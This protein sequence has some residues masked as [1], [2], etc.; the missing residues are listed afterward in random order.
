MTSHNTIR[1]DVDDD[2]KPVKFL[3]KLLDYV[4]DCTYFIQYELGTKT[5][6]QHWQGW[7]SH[8]KTDETFR[9]FFNGWTSRELLL[10]KS[11]EKSFKKVRRDLTGQMSYILKCQKKIQWGSE[12]L[13]Y[14][15]NIP[16][17]E[18]SEIYERIPVH[19]EK[20]QFLED[21]G[22]KIRKKTWHQETMEMLEEKCISRNLCLEPQINYEMVE[23]LVGS[24][25]PK[26][27]DQ[28]VYD[29]NVLGCM[30]H[31]EQRHPNQYN[32]RVTHMFSR[33][34]RDKYADVFFKN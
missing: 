33:N 32:N 2:T 24:R 10:K 34:F 14:Y 15:T 19:V 1:F 17:A 27:L 18:L 21:N 29:R 5:Q 20:G 4:P 12:L 26:S 9:L 23:T 22:I 31:L 11:P 16:E 8:N 25:L 13:K 6:K 28:M 3:D 30:F 7:V